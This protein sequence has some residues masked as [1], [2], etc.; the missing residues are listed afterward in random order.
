MD[1]EVHSAQPSNTGC[2]LS[3]KERAGKECSR[4][5][6]TGGKDKSLKI[7]SQRLFER[8]TLQRSMMKSV[9]L[10]IP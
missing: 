5:V 1:R 9:S 8:I 3:V 6:G 4:F 10:S 2:E 7:E